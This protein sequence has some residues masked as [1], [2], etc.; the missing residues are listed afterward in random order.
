M[1]A[2]KLVRD[3]IPDIIRAKGEFPSTRVVAGT[4][5]YQKL[6]FAK[7]SEEVLEFIASNGDPMELAD[8]LEVV[9][10]LAD[11]LGIG[12]QELE[13]LRAKKA[14]E[15]GGFSAGIVWSGNL[16]AGSATSS[17]SM[18]PVTLETVG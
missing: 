1:G 8:I 16:P 6:L 14:A 12:Q 10:A 3:K 7:L 2:E 4:E 9:M 11:D 15:R 13:T 17:E 5:E 18:R